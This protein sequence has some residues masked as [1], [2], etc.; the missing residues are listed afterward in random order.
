MI[1]DDINGDA[2][3]RTRPFRFDGIDYEI[4]LTDAHFAELRAAL[5][6]YLRAARAVGGV[7]TAKR[8]SRGTKPAT[9]SDAA[10][11]RA[12]ARSLGKPV[13]ERGR[14][15][16]ELRADWQAAGSPR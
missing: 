5:K 13:T 14:V 7:P 12:W 6:P 8:P 11:I 3:A 16:A 15:T 4:D 10:A 9:A 1:V 2:G